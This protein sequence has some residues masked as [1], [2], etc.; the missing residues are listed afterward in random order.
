MDTDNTTKNEPESEEAPRRRPYQRPEITEWGSIMDLTA[1]GLN[2]L[3]DL[4]AG[5]GTSPA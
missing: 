1:G 4:P 3:D 2:G 5:G